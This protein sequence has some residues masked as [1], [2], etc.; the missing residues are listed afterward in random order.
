[1]AELIAWVEFLSDFEPP[2]NPAKELS[3]ADWQ[4]LLPSLSLLGK[5]KEDLERIG[6][7]IKR[8]NQD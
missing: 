8:K 3:E 1:T 6:K 2:I 4:R 7:E 5:N